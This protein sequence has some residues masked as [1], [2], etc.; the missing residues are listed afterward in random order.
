M[1]ENGLVK[2]EKDG[3][4]PTSKKQCRTL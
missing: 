4:I 2:I 3:I 1:C